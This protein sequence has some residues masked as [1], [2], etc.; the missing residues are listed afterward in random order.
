MRKIFDHFRYV[1]QK[2]SDSIHLRSI[3]LISENFFE[4]DITERFLMDNV[5]Q[6]GVGL[7]KLWIEASQ[8]YMDLGDWLQLISDIASDI[9]GN[10]LL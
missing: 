5:S 4:N 10:I 9:L 6:K 3:K 2:I 7:I 1:L 8:R